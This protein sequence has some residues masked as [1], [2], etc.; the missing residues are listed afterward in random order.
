[1]LVFNEWLPKVFLLIGITVAITGGGVVF[2]CHGLSL[3][4]DRKKLIGLVFMGSI[5]VLALYLGVGA[6]PDLAKRD[7]FK[8]H[9]T[10]IRQA[11]NTWKHQPSKMIVVL[12]HRLKTHPEDHT[13][14]RL[15]AS[16]YLRLHHFKQAHA[17]LWPLYQTR[18]VDASISL[19]MAEIFQ[20]QKRPQASLKILK[21]LMA[22]AKV[23]PE[24][25]WI[26][27]ELALRV[28]APTLTLQAWRNARA[29]WALS[30]QSLK[31]IDQA[32]DQLL[33]QMHSR[34]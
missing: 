14:R 33:K 30:G 4:H 18:H 15:L 9:Q 19:M 7:F 21:K 26:I 28:Q 23:A 34:K 3:S 29:Q 6:L 12:E 5:F 27:G 20:G 24:T 22:Q 11:L 31:V 10:D 1:M 25:A 13:A 17:T 2:C 8:T 32:I 16:V